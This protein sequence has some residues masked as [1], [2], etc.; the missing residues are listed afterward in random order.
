MKDFEREYAGLLNALKKF[1]IDPQTP[2]NDPG[3]DFR[4]VKYKSVEFAIILG[5][6]L[7]DILMNSPKKGKKTLLNNISQF[8]ITLEM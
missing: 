5:T 3:I 6:K 4:Y 2:S 1:K 8:F 7:R